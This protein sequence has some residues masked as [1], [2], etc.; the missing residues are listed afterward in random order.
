MAAYQGELNSEA[1]PSTIEANKNVSDL[2]EQSPVAAG[3]FAENGSAIQVNSAFAALLDA[4]KHA[5]LGMPMQPFIPPSDHIIWNEAIAS[6]FAKKK[7]KFQIDITLISKTGRRVLALAIASRHGP[8]LLCHFIDI[9]NRKKTED[10][11]R[12]TERRFRDIAEATYDQFW[13][14]DEKFSFTY[15]YDPRNVSSFPGPS[16]QLGKRKWEIEGFEPFDRSSLSEHIDDLLNHRPFRD[17]RFSITDPAGMKYYW[18]SSGRPM[19]DE[20]GKFIGYRGISTNITGRTRAEQA[21]QQS[22][23]RFRAI[24]DHAPIQ[25]HIRDTT[26]RYILWNRQAAKFFG[27][28]ETAVLGRPASEFLPSDIAKILVDNDAAILT[29]NE[30]IKQEECIDIAGHSCTFLTIKF[31]IR[32]ESQHLI[33]IGSISTDITERKRSDEALRKSQEDI[34][35]HAHEMAHIQRI[36]TMNEMASAFAHQINQPINAVANY[37]SVCLHHLEGKDWDKTSFQKTLKLAHDQAIGAGRLVRDLGDFIRY[38]EPQ[39]TPCDLNKIVRSVAA[40]ME[41]E[42]RRHHTKLFL[43]LAPDLPLAPMEK[44]EIE[45]V[46]LNLVV[47]GMEAVRASSGE[48]SVTISTRAS[49]AYE[50]VLTVKDTGPGV[51]EDM[52]NTMFEAFR[53]SKPKGIGI[54]LAISRSIINRHGGKLWAEKNDADGAR[55]H[56]MLPT[57]LNADVKD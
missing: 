23:S 14:T 47:N 9:T 57:D 11:L 41:S 21:L 50:L 31:P 44:I 28:P 4:Q 17:F 26:G 6:L 22:E 51:P 42:L 1:P 3:I 52:W 37:T 56:F 33:G 36:A 13:E 46:I 5:I 35:R 38:A 10:K 16:I 24:V 30:S 15:V 39:I 25:I 49:E 7:T 8:Q 53:S 32:N 43:D 2:F 34:Q 27:I 29:S 45:Q 18:R 40:L 54:G 55:F 48:R 12:E 20:R 19:H